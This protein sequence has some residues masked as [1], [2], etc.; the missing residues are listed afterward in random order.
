MDFGGSLGYFQVHSWISFFFWLHWVFVAG[1]RLSVV[2]VSGGCS[3]LQCVVVSLRWLLLF[4]SMGSGHAS[5][6]NAACRL[7][8]PEAYGILVLCPGI[9]PVSPAFQCGF[10]TTGPPGKSWVSI[11]P[12]KFLLIIWSEHIVYSGEVLLVLMNSF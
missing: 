5:S 9:E 7:S 4:Q 2:A 10:L 3:F 8:F 11:L 12:E 6:V 1:L